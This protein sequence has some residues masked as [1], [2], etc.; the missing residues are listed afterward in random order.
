LSVAGD[1]KEASHGASGLLIVPTANEP[2]TPDQRKY[3]QLVKKIDALRARLL[4]LQ[5]AMPAF[6]ATYTAR[7]TPLMKELARSRQALA[8]KMAG[9]LA[10]PLANPLSRVK[11]PPSDRQ[12]LVRAFCELAEELV[13]NEFI[14]DAGVAELTALHDQ[15]AEVSLAQLVQADR[16]DFKGYFEHMTGVDLGDQP[17]DTHEA[18]VSHAQERL[19][20][21]LEAR[22]KAEAEAALKRPKRP[23]AAQRKRAAK[24]EQAQAKEQAASQSVREI[25]RKLA[26]ALHPDRASDEADR[27]ERTALMQRV[28]QAYEAKDLLALFA[29]QL[30]IEQV[31]PE[32]LARASAERVRHYN[33]V[34]TAQLRELQHELEQRQ[35]AFAME[36][37]IVDDERMN[38]ATLSLV[39]DDEVHQIR[40]A[41]DTSNHE[42]AQ[43][44]EPKNLKRWLK[45]TRR[46]HSL[47]DDDPFGMPF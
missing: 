5:T 33:Q 8:L 4:E 42:L 36:F 9:L 22:E 29:L 17:F 35:T 1:H 21:D 43:L 25:Y 3:N 39:L 45:Q 19:A 20:A 13:N 6:A 12:T 41:I 44:D 32:H 37:G 26:S 27:A 40:L 14:D 28:N 16:E 15:Y 38:A 47:N 2:L 7:M 46:S 24:A 31:D 30:E 10:N 11:P 18:F 34:L 23:S